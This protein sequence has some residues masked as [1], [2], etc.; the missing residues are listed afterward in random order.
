LRD[1]P[2]KRIAGQRSGGHDDAVAA[3]GLKNS[4]D[5]FAPHFNERMLRDAFGDGLRKKITVNG[6][7]VPCRY[8]HLIGNRKRKTSERSQF[9]LQQPRRCVL[10][11]ALQ[12]V[13][14]D[15][16]GHAVRL[17][18]RRER[19]RTHLIENHRVSVFRSL[20]CGFSACKTGTKHMYVTFRQSF[21]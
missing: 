2:G 5:F 16:L 14:A 10:R 18:S 11:L 9:L 19:D 4:F 21:I 3:L 8:A 20:E 15:E 12:R 17:M 7:G 6:E 1:V 13:A